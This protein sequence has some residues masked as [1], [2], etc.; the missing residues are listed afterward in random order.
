MGKAWT[1]EEIATLR[2]MYQRGESRAAVSI[3]IGRSITSCST[4]ANELGIRM[5]RPGSNAPLIC[6]RPGMT[7][8]ACL[9]CGNEFRSEGPHNRLCQNCRGQSLSPLDIPARVGL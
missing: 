3:A 9:C 4:K 8:R 5:V 7:V 1:P 6:T 2:E